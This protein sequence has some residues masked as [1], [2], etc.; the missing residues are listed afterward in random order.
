MFWKKRSIS[1]SIKLTL[2]TG[3]ARCIYFPALSAVLKPLPEKGSDC[4]ELWSL[5]ILPDGMIAELR[6]R[7]F[8]E[9]AVVPWNRS[10][11]RV[12]NCVTNTTI[13]WEYISYPQ[14]SLN[15]RINKELAHAKHSHYGYVTM[16]YDVFIWRHMTSGNSQVWLFGHL[17]KTKFYL[18]M[19]SHILDW[20][21]HETT[22]TWCLI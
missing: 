5:W 6:I 18:S 12:V 16:S 2:Q 21:V 22:D 20:S 14:G 15:T 7:Q 11:V 17:I 1:A 8:H 3:E 9:F 10:V 4:L 13:S 19:W